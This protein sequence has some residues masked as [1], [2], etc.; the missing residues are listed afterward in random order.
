MRGLFL[1]AL[2]ALAGCLEASAVR[3][4]DGTVC[5][6]GTECSLEGDVARCLVPGQV[7]ACATSPY[8]DPC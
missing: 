6:A 2:F 4:A 5:P 3:C 1:A 8:G 7:A